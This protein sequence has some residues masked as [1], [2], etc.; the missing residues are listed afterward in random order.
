[1]EAPIHRVV[2]LPLTLGTH[3]K[4]A[5]SSTWSIIG[6]VLYNR[7][8]RPTVGAIGKRIAVAPVIGV[9]NLLQT[10][11]AGGD[12]WRNELIPSLLSLAT[13]DF[14]GCVTDSWLDGNAYILDTR[15]RWG[16]ALQLKEKII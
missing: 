10:G 8:A 14:K 1:M 3:P 15:Q 12:V 9:K 7:E 16:F 13:P 11:G 2:V 6:D 5:H 4:A